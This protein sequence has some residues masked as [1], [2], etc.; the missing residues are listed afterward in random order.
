MNND[1][2]NNLK[3]YNKLF[4]KIFRL[5]ITLALNHF[6]LA[7]APLYST[8]DITTPISLQL[9]VTFILTINSQSVADQNLSK[10]Y[11]Q[12]LIEN[13]KFC[14]ITRQFCFY[15]VKFYIYHQL[16]FS[17]FVSLSVLNFVLFDVN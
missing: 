15:F 10:T 4:R 7:H 13:C 16:I 8:W 3:M 6:T 12:D 11:L 14:L 1:T 5:P 2:N 9:E 17:I